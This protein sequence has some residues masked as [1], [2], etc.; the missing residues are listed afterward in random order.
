M[1]I[2]LQSYVLGF[3]LDTGE[4]RF[5]GNINHD[6]GI[7]FHENALDIVSVIEGHVC[8]WAKSISLFRNMFSSQIN[9]AEMRILSLTAA[10]LPCY[11]LFQNATKFESL[12]IDFPHHCDSKRFPTNEIFSEI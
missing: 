1:G 2:Q 12:A 7:S 3:L 10:Y 9:R 4:S 5:Y 8:F 6:R 11:I